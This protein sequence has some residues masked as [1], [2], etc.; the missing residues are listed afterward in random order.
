MRTRL[1]LIVAGLLVASALIVLLLRPSG[2]G[3]AD[4]RKGLWFRTE[5]ATLN[6]DPFTMADIESRKIATLLHA[7]LVAVDLDGTVQARV[8][9]SWE[10]SDSDTWRFT[11]RRNVRFS[12]GREVNPNAVVSSLTAAMQPGSL[13]AWSLASIAHET[14]PDGSVAC[15][16]LVA[17]DE[18][19]VEIRETVATPWLFEA[20]AGPA[21]WIVQAA[22]KAEPHGLRPGVGP[23]VIES[24]KPDS[25]IVLSA[26]RDNASA[27]APQAE[28]IQFRYLPDPAVAAKA[29]A[30]GEID[31]LRIDTPQMYDMLVDEEGP[32]G[33]RGLRVAGELLSHSFSR[34]RILI[35]NEPALVRRGWS[36]DDIAL[37]RRAYSA[38]VD[39][40]ALVRQAP[41][42]AMPLFTSFPPSDRSPNPPDESLRQVEES[43]TFD[44]TAL[45]LL[46]NNDPYSDLI[47]SLLPSRLGGA[48][49]RYRAVDFG[50][51]VSALQNG[52][53]D[54]IGVSLDATIDAPAFWMAFFQPDAPFLLFGK[55]L[56]SLLNVRPDTADEIAQAGGIIDAEGNWIPLF[57]EEGLLALGPRVQG[58]RLTRSGQESLESSA[59]VR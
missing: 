57:R 7:G 50:V 20:L 49:I 41:G 47:A 10:R 31:M 4:A 37:F 58:L 44:G 27:V 11:I 24:F 40:G 1:G 51:I 9:S 8:A 54:L 17:V 33:K 53:H 14:R 56:P 43:T 6:L 46:V 39:R 26:R 38:A 19:T 21:G 3:T 42:R 15:T 16:G 29:F 12:D 36:K 5:L 52:D 59:V 48:T 22:E 45:S 55:P 35:V 32:D 23:Y 13:W 28:K 2:I 30:S 25:L 34:I 18:E